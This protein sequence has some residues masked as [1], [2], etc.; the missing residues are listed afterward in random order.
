MKKIILLAVSLLLLLTFS[1]CGGGGTPPAASTPP[2]A[3]VPADT[4]TG[5]TVEILAAV[6][7][8]AGE[9]AEAPLPQSF[10]DQ[11]TAENCQGMLGLTPEQFAEYVTD[12]Y[13]SNAAL[14]TSAHEVALVKCNDPAAAAEVK[15]L[16]AEGFDSQ[17]WVCVLPDESSVV[18]SGSYVL[19][20]ATSSDY[21]EAL[22]A[23]FTALA[24]DNTGEK[25]VFYTSPR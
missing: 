6:V 8:A 21:A 3:E 9:A 20:L 19:L 23:G 18:D 5:E 17:K 7:A 11:V 4:L 14:T 16:I 15:A 2:P 24:A 22:T 10:E 13:V 12:A 25:I 1:A